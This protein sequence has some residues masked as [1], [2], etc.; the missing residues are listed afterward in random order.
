MQ[1]FQVWGLHLEAW[2]HPLAELSVSEVPQL[3]L[4][5][6]GLGAV[7]ARHVVGQQWVPR[8]QG[9][10]ERMVAVGGGHDMGSSVVIQGAHGCRVWTNVG[11]HGGY[12]G[13]RWLKG[14]APVDLSYHLHLT[15]AAVVGG[16]GGSLETQHKERNCDS[17]V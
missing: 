9:H 17:F 16:A 4:S 11:G 15:H 6:A 14:G 10:V 2:L 7:Q 1:S 12:S 8:A 3:A 5:E 13:R